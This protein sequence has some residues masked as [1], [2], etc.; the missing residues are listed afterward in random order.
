M[1]FGVGSSDAPSRD[2][3]NQFKLPKVGDEKAL[4][5][6]LK[7]IESSEDRT[8]ESKNRR[9]VHSIIPDAADLLES[10]SLQQKQLLQVPN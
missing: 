7:E 1:T 2:T 10:S 4:N 3:H 9:N 5:R 8:L 6:D